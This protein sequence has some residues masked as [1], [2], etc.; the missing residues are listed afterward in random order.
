MATAYASTSRS[1]RQRSSGAP[2]F[3]AFLMAVIS[4]FDTPTICLPLM[5]AN[6][7]M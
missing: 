5:S 7:W 3:L 4:F 1:M 2:A 6:D